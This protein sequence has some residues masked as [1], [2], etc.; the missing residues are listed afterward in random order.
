M[1]E[2]IKE[3]PET[4]RFVGVPLACDPATSV[5]VLYMSVGGQRCIA[6]TVLCMSGWGPVSGLWLSVEQTL[7]LCEK[8][9]ASG[10]SQRNERFGRH[11]YVSVGGHSPTAPNERRY[12]PADQDFYMSFWGVMVRLGRTTRVVY[13]VLPKVYVS[14]WGWPSPG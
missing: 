13:I 3:R 14:A 12:K 9:G 8:L 6:T 2:W 7:C 10:R 1:A 11:L 4:H 5:L